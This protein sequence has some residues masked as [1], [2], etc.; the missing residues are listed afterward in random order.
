MPEEELR[1]RPGRRT[2]SL[3]LSVSEI[4][5]DMLTLALRYPYYDPF[6]H[7]HSASNLPP[8]PYPHIL[9]TPLDIG[10]LLHITDCVTLLQNMPFELLRM[11]KQTVPMHC[12]ANPM[13]IPEHHLPPY[14]TNVPKWEHTVLPICKFFI[15][16]LLTFLDS[17]SS[18]YPETTL[19][20]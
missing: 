2:L 17:G 6:L 15:G 16:K 13:L 12:M 18:I 14:V 8:P 9:V 19:K 20:T 7:A 1:R 4:S 11:W 3:S 5:I 10:K